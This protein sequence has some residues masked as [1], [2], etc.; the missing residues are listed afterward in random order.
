MIMTDDCFIIYHF[1]LVSL[2]D[3]SEINFPK[4]SQLSIR[5]CGRVSKIKTTGYLV[6]LGFIAQQWC[7]KTDCSELSP[8]ICCA[9]IPVRYSLRSNYFWHQLSCVLVTC[10]RGLDWLIDLLDTRK[11]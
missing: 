6:Q 10:R 7:E 4:Y 8:I 9:S 1:I 2:K 5:K 3:P 11:S